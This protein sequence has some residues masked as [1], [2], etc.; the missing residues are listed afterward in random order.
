M[1][2]YRVLLSL[3]RLWELQVFTKEVLTSVW[4]MYTKILVWIDEKNTTPS[5]FR[6]FLRGKR[7]FNERRGKKFVLK[8]YILYLSFIQTCLHLERLPGI[9]KYYLLSCCCYWLSLHYAILS[10]I[11]V[12]KINSKNSR[13]TEGLREIAYISFFVMGEKLSRRLAKILPFPT[14]TQLLRL[15]LFLFIS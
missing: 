10:F 11:S 13:G 9:F 12:F 6:T 2:F 14:W 7:T 5:L 1:G 4:K 8:K 15:C 3:L